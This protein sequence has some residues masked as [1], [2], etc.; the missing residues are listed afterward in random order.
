M[1]EDGDAEGAGGVEMAGE[2]LFKPELE[3]DGLMALGLGALA[4][5]SLCFFVPGNFQEFM[6]K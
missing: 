6:L 2:T 3:T 4:G 1:D 5:C